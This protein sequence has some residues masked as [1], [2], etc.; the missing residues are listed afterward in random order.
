MSA[1]AIKEPSDLQRQLRFVAKLVEL[2]YS[3]VKLKP[4]GS[5]QKLTG[6]MRVERTLQ[7]LCDLEEVSAEILIKT[8][9]ELKFRE[10]SKHCTVDTS[11]CPFSYLPTNEEPV[12]PRDPQAH[13]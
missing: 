4:G 8:D 7:K 11:K 10:L 6:L 9:G 2:E 1:A 3:R 5:S 12:I 13:D